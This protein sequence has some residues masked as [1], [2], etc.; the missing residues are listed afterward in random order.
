MESQ[1]VEITQ[2]FFSQAL[3]NMP[4]NCSEA[5]ELFNNA[6]DQGYARAQFHMGGLYQSSACGIE[7][8]PCEAAR[9]F[10]S[11]VDEVSE[12]MFFLNELELRGHLQSCE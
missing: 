12:A 4:Q 5:V 7:R 11:V 10:R 3:S 8:D 1:P 9:L 2:L 6:A